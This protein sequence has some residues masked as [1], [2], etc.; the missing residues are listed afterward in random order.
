MP[1]AWLV[2][3]KFPYNTHRGLIFQNGNRMTQLAHLDDLSRLQGSFWIALDGKTLFIHPFGSKDPNNDMFEIGVQS[4]L[5]RPEEVG[6]G[7]VRLTGITFEHCAN[8]FLRTGTGAVT[9]LGGHHWIID[10]NTIRQNNSS[11]LEF[12]HTAFESNDKN[13]LNKHFQK[14]VEIGNVIVRNNTIYDCGTAGIRSFTVIDGIIENNKIYNCG[15]QDAENYWEVAGIKLLSA[16]NTLIRNNH[17]YNIQ[18][19]NEIWLDWDNR[20]SRVTGNLI[21]DVRTMQGG[22]FVEASQYPNMVD[23]NIIWDIDGNGILANDTKESII[24]HNLIINTSKHYINAISATS[25]KLN[26]QPVAAE[27]NTILNNI[28]V[29]GTSAFN[30]SSGNNLIDYNLY[31]TSIEPKYIDLSTLKKSNIDTH[32]QEIRASFKIL[33]SHFL[34][35]TNDTVNNVPTLPYLKSSILNIIRNGDSTSPGPF[36]E[37]PKTFRYFF[38]K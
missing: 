28:F 15:W 13:P 12:G 1:W 38:M 6:L 14:N 4:H 37:M 24:V 32:G 31:A 19:G 10:N 34:W 3:E 7:Y 33:P 35:Q 30:L 16:T 29:D 17:I 22:I 36:Q 21:H 26:G 18:G 11:G 27:K 5:F 23:N 20:F 8:G 25:R 9:I 2:K